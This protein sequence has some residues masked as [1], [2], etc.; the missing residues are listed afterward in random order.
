M[1]HAK[2]IESIATALLQKQETI[3]VAESVTSGFLQAALSSADNA[4]QFFQG[5]ITAYNLEQKTRHLNIDPIHA[6]ACNCVS[7]KMAIDMAISVGS[8]YSSHWA[9]AVTGYATPVPESEGKIYAY[10]A[11]VYEG[12]VMEAAKIAC[13]QKAPEKVQL[14]YVNYIADQLVK[15][16]G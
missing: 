11:I 6:I 4:I 1:F 9:I 15:L 12:K 3:A 13:E 7:Q 10:Y 14:Y 2:S 5:G 16:L 8:N